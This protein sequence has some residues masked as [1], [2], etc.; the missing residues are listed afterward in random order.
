MHMFLLLRT[1]VPYKVSACVT[2]HEDKHLLFHRTRR[3]LKSSQSSSV[4]QSTKA[5]QPSGGKASDAVEHRS[6][7]ATTSLRHDRHCWVPS[8]R[9]ALPAGHEAPSRPRWAQ[10]GAFVCPRPGSRGG[11]GPGRQGLGRAAHTMR[12][13]CGAGAD[14]PR[15]AHAYDVMRL[16]CA[17]R[18]AGPGRAASQ[19]LL[20]TRCRQRPDPA[21]PTALR[22]G[23]GTATGPSAAPCP[24]PGTTPT[25]AS[26][27]HGTRVGPPLRLPTRLQVSQEAP[28]KTA[29]TGGH[30]RE[31]LYRATS[32]RGSPSGAGDSEPRRRTLF[33]PRLLGAD[34]ARSSLVLPPL[35]PVPCS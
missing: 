31:H 32:R 10:H 20:S 14:W 29:L 17:A 18:W 24:L 1:T 26:K 3:T 2:G 9:T 23:L 21:L 30:R 27:H 16:E 4:K 8:L 6:R 12:G 13:L 25:K 11:A 5:A 35:P 33:H 7:R 28:R 15:T 22:R 19:P 34:K